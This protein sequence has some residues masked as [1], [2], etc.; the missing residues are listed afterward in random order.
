MKPGALRTWIVGLFLLIVSAAYAGDQPI[1]GARVSVNGDAAELVDGARHEKLKLVFADEFND[2]RR[3]DGKS[4]VWRTAY[5][6]AAPD[7]FDGRTMPWDKQQQLY[8]DPDYTGAGKTPLG[9]N[10]FKIH[11]G[12]LDITADRTPPEL[13]KALHGYKYTSGLITT[14]DRFEQAY[15]YYEIRA[16]LPAGKGL[17][18]AFWLAPADKTWPPEIDIFEVLGQEPKLLYTTVHFYNKA[19]QH[20]RFGLQLKVDD[21]SAAFHTYGVAWTPATIR[22]FIDRR[23]VAT[24]PTPA[25]VNKPMY[26]LVNLGVGGGW[27]GPVDD[28]TRFPAT[29]SVDYVRVYQFDPAYTPPAPAKP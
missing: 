14:K 19:G 11:D 9:L 10:P 12:V 18:P 22:F 7:N 8:V 25:N 4:G 2:F 13:L 1:G 26:V 29:M 23:E 21:T 27:P 20:D 24:T 15:G 28:T 16:K 17:W 3:Y 6:F 5:W